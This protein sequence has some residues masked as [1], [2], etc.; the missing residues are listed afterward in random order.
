MRK[1]SIVSACAMCF[2]MVS[3]HAPAP[4]QTPV[5]DVETHHADSRRLESEASILLVPEDARRTPSG[6]AY[7]SLSPGSGEKPDPRTAV[8]VM[9]R[10]RNLEGVVTDEARGTMAIAHSS[11]FFEEILPLMSLGE[12]VRVWGE[13]KERI[14]EIE[15]ISVNE[16][17]LPPSD[18]AEPPGDAQALSSFEDVKWRVV[19]LGNG[20]K[21]SQGQ[22]LRVHVTRWNR[23]G[24][25]LESSR[26]GK[27][28]LLFMNDAQKKADP[29]HHDIFLAMRDG[30]H[31]RVWIPGDRLLHTEDIV[32]DI[33][34]EEV[35]EGLRI[36]ATEPPRDA[37]ALEEV[38]LKYEVASG[39]N[40]L[41]AGQAVE[42]EMA[43]WHGQD[44]IDA[45][46]L[47]GRHDVMELTEKLGVWMDIMTSV[48]PGDV[49]VTWIP[50]SSLPESVG[51][52]LTCRVHVYDVVE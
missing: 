37:L 41:E 42:V 38:R 46:Y 34:I 44:L 17:Y 21:I 43:C 27:G 28:M 32:E 18:V 29:V 31:I 11:P 48:A 26:A 51:M 40:K 50:A 9:L 23:A 39:G 2:C 3:C 1:N 49:F 13:S 20:E 24:E 6:L 7:I 30:E 45:S 33:W 19:E 5:Q 36:P 47:R 35:L 16:A 15:M 14:W 4:L 25:I 10:V 22:A 12:T 52:D 8:D